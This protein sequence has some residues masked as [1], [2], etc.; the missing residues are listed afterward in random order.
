MCP[1][2]GTRISDAPPA[3]TRLTAGEFSSARCCNSPL[4]EG[5]LPSCRAFAASGLA[6]GLA[7]EAGFG[8][9]AALILRGEG[10]LSC[11]PGKS[12]LRPYFPTPAYTPNP[13]TNRALKS[14]SILKSQMNFE[15]RTRQISF[16]SPGYLDAEMKRT[17]ATLSGAARRPPV[18]PATLSSRSTHARTH[19]GAPQ[20]CPHTILVHWRGWVSRPA[21]VSEHNGGDGTP[22]SSSAVVRAW[23]AAYLAGCC[24]GGP[25]SAQHLWRGQGSGAHAREPLRARRHLSGASGEAMDGVTA[26]SSVTLTAKVF[27][28]GLD[29][30]VGRLACFSIHPIALLSA[31]TLRIVQGWDSVRFARPHGTASPGQSFVTTGHPPHRPINAGDRDI[32]RKPDRQGIS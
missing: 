27:N 20:A 17:M 19:Q 1:L 8:K 26:L 15:I 12:G 5:A 25:A 30:M 14:I 10:G 7:S 28:D 23:R 18:A 32:R 13:T 9:S 2:A 29:P 31:H 16:R 3:G 22:A 21:G 11:N 4:L 24:D 6:A